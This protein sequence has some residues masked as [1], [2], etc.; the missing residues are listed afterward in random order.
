MTRGGVELNLSQSPYIMETVNGYR[1]HF[2]SRF[3]LERFLN[4]YMNNRI[5]TTQKLNKLFGFSVH[6]DILCDIMYYSKIEKRGFY[7]VQGVNVFKNIWEVSCIASFIYKQLKGDNNGEDA[8]K[9][10]LGQQ[11]ENETFS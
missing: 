7:V 4:G 2:S 9:N 3:Y 1:F 6:A 10:S 5:E 8:P 11:N